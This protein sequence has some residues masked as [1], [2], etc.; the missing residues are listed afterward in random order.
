M[1]IAMS[2]NDNHLIVTSNADDVTG[3]ML[4]GVCNFRFTIDLAEDISTPVWPGYARGDM[5]ILAGAQYNPTGATECDL[6]ATGNNE[7]L[8][9]AA[10][11]MT[12]SWL[13]QKPSTNVQSWDA[14]WQTVDPLRIAV[15][16][17][18]PGAFIPNVSFGI[19]PYYSESIPAET[20]TQRAR[21]SCFYRVLW[22]YP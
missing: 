15:E 3:V 21:A 18:N 22:G 11:T 4:G 6:K 10:L 17:V 12:G 13:W 1:G 19:L 14:Y 7:I 9:S 16:R 20:L 8:I 5:D 2:W